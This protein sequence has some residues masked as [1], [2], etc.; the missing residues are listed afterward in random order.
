MED[1]AIVE[2]ETPQ[3][4]GQVVWECAMVE[5]Q[6]LMAPETFSRLFGRSKGITRDGTRL[7]VNLGV[8]GARQ[9]IKR[10]YEEQLLRVVNRWSDE[11]IT[12]IA[13]VLPTGP[14]A[15]E[16]QKNALVPAAHAESADEP[17]VEAVREE[18]VVIGPTTGRLLHTDFYIKLKVAFRHRALAELKG[19]PLSV[20]LCLALHVDRDGVAYPGVQTIMRETGYSRSVVCSALGTL[21]D[22][23]LMAKRRAHRGNDEYII[24]GYAWFGTDPA[25]C[26]WEK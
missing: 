22:L 8:V 9:W 3:V 11:P 6:S 14:D 13:Y 16:C 12:E 21:V 25:P 10:G 20:F 4:D 19:A 18:R 5:M 2:V 26:L 24:Q 23:G 15:W 7:I 1:Q 17:I